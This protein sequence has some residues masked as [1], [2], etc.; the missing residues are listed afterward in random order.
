MTAHPLK[1]RTPKGNLANG[2]PATLLADLCDVVIEARNAGVLQKQQTH[3]ARRCELLMRGFAR[4][5]I[6]GL[7]DEATG[8]Q[9]IRSKR[10]LATILE[11]WIAEKHQEW[12][13][14]T[15]L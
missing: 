9:K 1:F 2:Y 15:N 4:L 8:Y 6:I 5:G 10:A 13:G 7:V 3:I 14:P 12:T 11:K